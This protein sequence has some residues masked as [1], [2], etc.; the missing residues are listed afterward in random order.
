TFKQVA[1]MWIEKERPVRSEG[2]I[3]NAEHLLYDYCAGLA[4]LRVFK[5]TPEQVHAALKDRLA[6]APEQTNRAR[7]YSKLVLDFAG[8]KRL[9]PHGLINAAQWDGLQEHLFPSQP[10]K[11]RKH[12]AAPPY[13]EIPSII[14]RTRTHEDRSV[15]AV[16]F[17]FAMYTVKRTSEVL[18]ARWIEID[19]ENGVWTISRERMKKNDEEEDHVVPLSGPAM[20][21]LFRRKQ[22]SRGSPYIFT[23]TDARKHLGQ[24]GMSG[25]FRRMGIPYTIHGTVRATFKQW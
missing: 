13:K 22:Q 16:A 11:G 4:D 5:I 3:Y 6:E 14:L 17:R 9:R 25:L 20:D 8:A 2:W 18:Q 24:H 21:I 1:K 12:H 19:L 23:S 10:K 7:R 15:G